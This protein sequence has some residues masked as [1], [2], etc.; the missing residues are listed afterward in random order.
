MQQA[1]VLARNERRALSELTRFFVAFRQQ[2]I[3]K[4]DDFNVASFDLRGLKRS[5]TAIQF[6]TWASSV[7]NAR[8]NIDE[9]GLRLSSFVVTPDMLSK[10]ED[11]DLVDIRAKFGEET[12]KIFARMT[13]ELN[14]GVR[15]AVK[16]AVESGLPPRSAVAHFFTSSGLSAG[17]PH[18]LK[19]IVR[20]QMQLVFNGAAK[21]EYEA[22]G[23]RDILWGYEYITVGDE[24]VR[25]EHA[26]LDG[27]KL[28]KDDPFWNRFWPPNGWNCRCQA[29]PIFAEEE[30]VSPPPDAEPD[31]GFGFDPSN[32][33]LTPLT[34]KEYTTPEEAAKQRADLETVRTSNSSVVYKESGF[35]TPQQIENAYKKQFGDL[36]AATLVGAPDGAIV[37]VSRWRDA[38]AVDFSFQIEVV[39]PD[40]S[41]M[42]RQVVV[43]KDGVHI[44]NEYLF[45]TDKEASK[46]L[47]RQILRDQ[48][49]ASRSV[50]VK[51][52]VTEA[53]GSYGDEGANGYYTWLRY[54]YDAPIHN[55][56]FFSDKKI[57]KR[58]KTEFPEAKTLLDVMAT[59]EG[60]A[61]WKLNGKPS[62][63][64][65][66]L[67]DNSR[68]M[69]VFTAYLEA[70]KNGN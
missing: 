32:I 62:L 36:D 41:V 38:D 60:R 66:D 19:S 64:T 35:S 68:S 44:K 55:K 59:E 58:I 2:A 30:A 31:Q 16:D 6:H 51:S 15:D 21:A 43:K 37:T 69:N 40:I 29:V 57:A 42:G 11:K 46:G 23:I 13:T 53:A 20:T 26:V 4:L 47:G 17:N 24:R 22:E 65:F 70:K 50:G 27:V 39:H 25:E 18:R 7:I 34:P 10:L 1:N 33:D 28:P 12:E 8:R 67:A 61:W 45:L 48:I 5:F 9:S 63:T 56:S 3:S 54:G 49:V 52:I 14:R